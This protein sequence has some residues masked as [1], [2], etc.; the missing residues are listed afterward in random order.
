[1]GVN[2][3][4]SRALPSS[5]PSPSFSLPKRPITAPAGSAGSAPGLLSLAHSLFGRKGTQGVEEAGRDGG[6]DGAQRE[7]AQAAPGQAA[8]RLR[9]PLF[10]ELSQDAPFEHAQPVLSGDWE[11]FELPP[12]DL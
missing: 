11:H 4:S 6:G 10:G 5:K 1:M 3:R 7:G 12:G 2:D 8:Q 9:L